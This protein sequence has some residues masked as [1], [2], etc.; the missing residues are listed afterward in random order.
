MNDKLEK[1]RFFCEE[2][3][4]LAKKY[5]LSESHVYKIVERR[6]WWKVGAAFYYSWQEQLN[7]GQK[8]WNTG[9]SWYNI[10]V[11]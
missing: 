9:I 11:I 5:D 4:Q 7:K 2:V 6:Y 10:I 3:R 1:A 8:G